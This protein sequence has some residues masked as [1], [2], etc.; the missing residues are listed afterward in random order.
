[1][2]DEKNNGQYNKGKEEILE[3]STTDMQ[4]LLSRF[5]SLESQKDSEIIISDSDEDREFFCRVALHKDRPVNSV[6]NVVQVKITDKDF[7]EVPVGK[8]GSI[9]IRGDNVFKGY[10]HDPKQTKESFHD[11]WF[12]TGDL[13]KIDEDDSVT[14]LG[15]SKNLIIY[16]VVNISTAESEKI[17]K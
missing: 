17:I 15:R 6:S 9:L 10:W 12:I 1:M 2:E 8:E 11:G 14:F 4:A 5:D 3:V 7:N 13:G 16:V